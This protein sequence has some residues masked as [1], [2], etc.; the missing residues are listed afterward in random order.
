MGSNKVAISSDWRMFK[1]G[2]EN[3]AE[4]HKNTVL[5][6]GLIDWLTDQRSL[7]FSSTSSDMQFI[8]I[9]VG[10]GETA[11]LKTDTSLETETYRDTIVQEF[12]AVVNSDDPHSPYVILGIEIPAGTDMLVISEAG[13]CSVDDVF[14][15]RCVLDDGF[16]NPASTIKLPEDVLIVQ[17]RITMSNPCELFTEAVE[18]TDENTLTYSQTRTFSSIM[19]VDGVKRLF[20]KDFGRD[21]VWT[22]TLGTSSATPTE[23]DTGVTTPIAA[24][25]VSSDVDWRAPGLSTDGAHLHITAQINDDIL[26]D[27][28]NGTSFNEFAITGGGIDMHSSWTPAFVMEGYLVNILQVT[29]E[30]EFSR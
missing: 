1:K 28:L 30:V 5:D 22:A 23:L 14:F 4:W 25:V 21:T 13:I 17:C 18:L 2:D 29:I 7:E 6:S 9:A 10:S 12:S 11:S 19:L 26:H 8:T 20:T 3:N 15:N 16:G 24:Q 27:D